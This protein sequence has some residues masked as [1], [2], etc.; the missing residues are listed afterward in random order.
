[1]NRPTLALM[2]AALGG[3][4]PAHGFWLD[5]FCEH[6]HEGYEQN[7]HWPSPYVC[8]DRVYAHA[9]FNTMVRNGWR[10]QNL[11]GQ[12]YF[13]PETT[14]LNEAGKIKLRWIATQA[15]PEFRQVF[16][17]RSFDPSVTQQRM[18]AVQEFT[19]GFSTDGNQVV[20][21]ETHLTSDGRPA[22]TV[23][24]VN[25]RFQENMPLPVLPAT[26]LGGDSQ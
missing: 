14:A 12:H 11:I 25:S 2:V 22:S 19:S 26:S 18:A 10:R 16:V 3:A 20:V 17:E 5:A 21:S 13:D 23:N 4:F 8:P 9:P 6:V 15:P 1:M 24:F 7:E